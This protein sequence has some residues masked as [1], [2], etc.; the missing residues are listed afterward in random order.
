MSGEI[1]QQIFDSVNK[2]KRILIALS[3][4]AN[5]DGLGAGLA[6]FEFLKKLEKEPELVSTVGDLGPYRFLPGIEN[7]KTEVSVFQS[8]VIS[9]AKTNAQLSE[10]SYEEQSDR[11]D[12]FLKPSSGKFSPQDVT[13]RTA[14]FPYDLIIV[15]DTPALEHLGV[16]YERNTDFFFETPIVNIDHHPNNEQFGEINLVDL[17]A[18]ST[19]EILAGLIE[20][21][22]AGLIDD[23]IATNLLTGIIVETNSFQHIKTT[24]KAFLKAS[25]LIAQGGRHQD[26]IRELYKTKNISLLKLWGRALA[27]LREVKDL[28]V[29]YSLL[30]AMDL[31]KSGSPEEDVFGVMQELVANLAGRKIVFLLAETSG[32]D[33]L[34]YFYFHPSVRAQ[35]VVETLGGQMLNGSMASLRVVGANILEVEKT[36]LEKLQKLKDQIGV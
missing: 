24:P 13:F 20:S 31:Q 35:L 18:T 15:L 22:E 9:V 4:N 8:F 25:S 33:V 1:E 10:L 26:I 32:G 14:K 27:R 17:T 16:L 11:V 23:R 19:A 6:L 34:G 5:G 36:V 2:A 29:A 12:I 28:Q 30:S 7:L 3:Q 21:F